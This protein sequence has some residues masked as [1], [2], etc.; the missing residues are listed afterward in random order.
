MIANVRAGKAGDCGSGPAGRVDAR[1]SLRTRP[2]WPEVIPARPGGSHAGK[3]DFLPYS[4]L[5]SGG[6]A[7]SGA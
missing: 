3:F 2:A 4:W 1:P 7:P 6:F 5:G